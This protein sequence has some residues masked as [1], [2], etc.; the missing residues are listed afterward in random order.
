MT[1]LAV[2]LLILSTLTTSLLAAPFVTQVEAATAS[3]KHVKHKR[4]R[5]VHQRPAAAN[6]SASPASSNRYDD[7]F[8]R[9]A[10]GGG[11]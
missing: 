10:A 3:S 8:D 2:R 6:S 5:V 11:Y 9:K 7:D 4:V 1:K